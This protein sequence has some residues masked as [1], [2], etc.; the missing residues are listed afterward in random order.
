VRKLICRNCG[1][2]FT[3]K[4]G[5]DS[6]NLCPKCFI[7]KLNHVAANNSGNDPAA[8][9]TIMDQPNDSQQP[10]PTMPGTP[11]EP[12]VGP[13]TGQEP[14]PPEPAE[15][16]PSGGPTAPVPEEGEKPAGE[17]GETPVGGETPPVPPVA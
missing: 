9:K 16:P 14:I 10:K 3:P 4:R 13:P 6:K 2:E 15:T 5:S 11:P 1:Q 8:N 12:P 17:G 7:Q